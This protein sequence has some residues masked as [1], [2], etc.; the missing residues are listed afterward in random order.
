MVLAGHFARLHNPR[1]MLSG[2][3]GDGGCLTAGM[4]MDRSSLC[5]SQQRLCLSAQEKATAA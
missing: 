1:K 2:A 3:V 4:S 5:A